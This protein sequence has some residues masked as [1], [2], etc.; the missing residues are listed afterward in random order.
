M[1]SI[2]DRHFLNGPGSGFDAGG[3]TCFRRPS[4]METEPRKQ[5]KE[6]VDVAHQS[7]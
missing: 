3:K 1:M 6:T 7:A 4:R 5:D 2:I